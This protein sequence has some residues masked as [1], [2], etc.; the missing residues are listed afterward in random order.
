[1]YSEGYW[2]QH[3]AVPPPKCIVVNSNPNVNVSAC[4]NLTD[5]KTCSLACTTGAPNGTAQA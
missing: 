5:G 4:A 2:D 1:M 3:R